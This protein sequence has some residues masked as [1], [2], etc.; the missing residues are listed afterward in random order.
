[1]SS[2]EILESINNI[3]TYNGIEPLYAP[4]ES[5]RKVLMQ[6]PNTT[7]NTGIYVILN[8]ISKHFYPGSA[9][10]LK[11]R[12]EI[13]KSRLNHNN[14]HC[15]HLQNAWNQ[16]CRENNLNSGSMCLV[17]QGRQKQHHGFKC[18]D[19]VKVLT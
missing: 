11:E 16:F 8:K 6:S 5:K 15:I 14:H 4:N 19:V 7:Y 12:W 9:V 17:S 18:L 10:D 2:G 1:M 13:H 3:R